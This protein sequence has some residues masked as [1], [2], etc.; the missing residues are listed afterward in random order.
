MLVAVEPGGGV[1][2]GGLV[3]GGVWPGGLVGGGVSPGAVVAVG[4]PS[5]FEF[6]VYTSPATFTILFCPD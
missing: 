5:Q 6:V 4:S 2:P 1:W 3:G